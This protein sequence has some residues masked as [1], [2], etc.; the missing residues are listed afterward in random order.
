MHTSVPFL[1]VNFSGLLLYKI[2][3]G[4]G[5]CLFFSTM[6]AMPCEVF[7]YNKYKYSKH[8]DNYKIHN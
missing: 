1:L 6:D 5:L 8:I 2:L 4:R 3:E 7:F